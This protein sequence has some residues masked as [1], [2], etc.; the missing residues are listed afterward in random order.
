MAPADTSAPFKRGGQ[1][2]T[3]TGRCARPHRLTQAGHSFQAVSPDSRVNGGHQQRGRNALSAYVAHRQNK[4]LGIQSQKI[5][6]VPAHRAG[7]TTEPENLQRRQ[8]RDVLRVEL[9]LHFLGDGQFVL[10][11]LL[12][13]LLLDQVLDGCGH[14]VERV[15]QRSQLVVRLHRNAMAE[16]SA[17][18]VFGGVI[19]LGHGAGHGAREAGSDPAAPEIR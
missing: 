15:G 14:G 12:L 4:F 9:G 3:G 7:G 2:K 11:S 16:V 19:E 18:D 17:I 5:V 13:L 1:Q 8:L 10:Q 6:V